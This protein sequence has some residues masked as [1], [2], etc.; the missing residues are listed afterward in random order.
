M[1]SDKTSGCGFLRWPERGEE[2][3]NLGILPGTT[4]RFWF[5]NL[6]NQK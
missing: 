3:L 6:N 1:I 4:Q 5:Y 2:D